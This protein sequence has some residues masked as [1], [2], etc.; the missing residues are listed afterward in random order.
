MASSASGRSFSSAKKTEKKT[1]LLQKNGGSLF[2]RFSNFLKA[3]PYC[4]LWGIT[5]AGMILRLIVSFELLQNDP[6]TSDPM[7]ESDMAT[8]I[9]I[10][11]GILQ[12]K[13]PDT[14]YYQPFYYTI[15]LLSREI[16]DFVCFLF[17][18]KGNRKFCT[19][20]ILDD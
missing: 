1:P 18:T 7:K 12:G 20:G 17:V 16:F 14:F 4:F 2:S 15:F 9:R 13:F 19:A 5:I 3:H 6:A 10:A 8:Y 11:D